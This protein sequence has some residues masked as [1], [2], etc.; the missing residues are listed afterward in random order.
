MTLPWGQ[1]FV[2]E[3]LEQPILEVAEERRIY[4]KP[5]Q[6]EHHD[7]DK[8]LRVTFHQV[9]KSVAITGLWYQFLIDERLM[10]HSSDKPSTL[11]FRHTSPYFLRSLDDFYPPGIT[12]DDLIKN[13]TV[14]DMRTATARAKA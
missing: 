5:V 1:R 8:R 9:E 10:L 13:L 14:V 4:G 6:T 7:I 11:R 12:A 3:A 2:P